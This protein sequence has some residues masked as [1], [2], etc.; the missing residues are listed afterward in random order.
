[1]TIFDYLKPIEEYVD[2]DDN[3]IY[4]YYCV[5]EVELSSKKENDLYLREFM[6][7]LDKKET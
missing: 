4:K 3:C 7:F 1:M 5:F 6:N 2:A